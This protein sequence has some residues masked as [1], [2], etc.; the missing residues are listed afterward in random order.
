MI[1]APLLHSGIHSEVGNRISSTEVSLL[2]VRVVPAGRVGL[3]ASMDIRNSSRVKV[4]AFSTMRSRAQLAHS[5]LS[6]QTLGT[7]IGDPEQRSQNVP[8]KG[9][10]HSQL[11]SQPHCPF[12]LQMTWVDEKGH[13]RNMPLN[14]YSL[15][16][17]QQ[18]IVQLLL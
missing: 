4:S 2:T 15:P 7:Q 8:R 10:L 12:P 18:T 13:V 14:N 11:P 3:P 6:L 16:P 1:T 9:S 5:L 17:L